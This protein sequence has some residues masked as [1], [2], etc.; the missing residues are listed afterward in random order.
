MGKKYIL[1]SDVIIGYLAGKI[2]QN[3]MKIIS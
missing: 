1:D 3:G 2:P